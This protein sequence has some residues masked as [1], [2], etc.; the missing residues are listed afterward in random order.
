MM[1]ERKKIRDSVISEE[2]DFIFLFYRVRVRACVE[3]W[4][5]EPF[6]SESQPAVW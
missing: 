4:Q 2:K 6:G 3:L 1:S 5:G